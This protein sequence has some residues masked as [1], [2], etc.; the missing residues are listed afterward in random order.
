M[1]TALIKPAKVAKVVAKALGDDDDADLDLI[2]GGTP[3]ASGGITTILTVYDR[4][5]GS[6]TRMCTRFATDDGAQS[7]GEGDRQGH[8]P[9]ADREA[10]PADSVHARLHRRSLLALQAREGR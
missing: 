1:K 2:A 5:D 7:E 6:L 8:G 10:R 4:S 9:Q 3:S